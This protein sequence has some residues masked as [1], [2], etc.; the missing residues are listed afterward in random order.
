MKMFLLAIVIFFSTLS[1][2]STEPSFTCTCEDSVISPK[3]RIF[4][5]DNSATGVVVLTDDKDDPKTNIEIGVAVESTNEAHQ[6]V[7]PI[8]ATIRTHDENINDQKVIVTFDLAF[9]DITQ[10]LEKNTNLDLNQATE[11]GYLQVPFKCIN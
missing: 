10:W 4:F 7:G 11:T 9:L 8:K 3:L 2:A 5:A 1:S 6:F